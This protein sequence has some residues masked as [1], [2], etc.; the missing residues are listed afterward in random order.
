MTWADGVYAIWAAVA[1]GALVSWWLSAADRPVG[2]MRLARA[3][4]LIRWLT[5]RPPLRIALLVLWMWVGWH[6]FAR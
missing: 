2:G 5:S 6:F 3:G 1:A 4:A